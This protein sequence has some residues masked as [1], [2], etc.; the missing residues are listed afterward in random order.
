MTVAQTNLLKNIPSRVDAN[1][2]LGM[3]RTGKVGSQHL[4]ALKD[5]TSFNDE[6]ISDWL[7]ISVKTFRSYKKPDSNIKPRIQEHSV[8]ALSVIKHGIEVFGSIERFTEWLQKKNFFFDKKPPIEFMNT[9]SGIK[10]IDDRL[11]GI[12]Y[13]DN[14]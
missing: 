14:A 9:N 6:K 11:T 3:V 2:T 1:I 4:Q 12:E 8:I 13:G 5:L 7:D 10:F